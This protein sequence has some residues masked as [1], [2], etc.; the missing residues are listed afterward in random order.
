MTLDANEAYEIMTEAPVYY[1]TAYEIRIVKTLCAF[2]AANGI[3]FLSFTLNRFQAAGLGVIHGY[4]MGMILSYLV[5][6]ITC[7]KRNRRII[8]ALGCGMLGFLAVLDWK[9]E[10]ALI[11]TSW[12]D[13]VSEDIGRYPVWFP[14]PPGPGKI[15]VPSLFTGMSTADIR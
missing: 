3:I 8:I 1:T 2:I 4:I 7:K 11:L 5:F 15:P 6:G 10:T 13:V 12:F 14:K 9:F